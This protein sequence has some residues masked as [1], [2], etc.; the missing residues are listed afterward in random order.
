MKILYKH[1]YRL[2]YYSDK[3]SF[4]QMIDIKTDKVKLTTVESADM[5]I[6]ILSRIINHLV[7]PTN[8]RRCIVLDD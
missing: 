4:I 8:D 3:S 6:E 5:Q 2:Y 1:G 7:N